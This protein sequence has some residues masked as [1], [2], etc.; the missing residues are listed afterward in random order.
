LYSPYELACGRV[1]PRLLMTGRDTT[2]YSATTCIK[3]AVWRLAAGAVEVEVQR[4]D[5]DSDSRPRQLTLLKTLTGSNAR[6]SGSAQHVPIA[7]GPQ[8]ERVHVI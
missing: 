5:L 8:R 4:P 1:P 2:S 6:Y 7:A 3:S